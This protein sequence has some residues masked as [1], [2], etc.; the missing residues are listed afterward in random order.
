VT[1]PASLIAALL[2]IVNETNR[3]ARAREAETFQKSTCRLKVSSPYGDGFGEERW[4]EGVH[5]ELF[6][7][8]EPPG[9]SC[10]VR[11]DRIAFIIAE[12]AITKI[13][14][15]GGHCP[16]EPEDLPH[17]EEAEGELLEKIRTFCESALS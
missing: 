12:E 4:I 2:E 5:V 11:E 8:H 10:A 6:I 13:R 9:P 14:F 17:T 7:T 15:T 1:E 3:R 16:E